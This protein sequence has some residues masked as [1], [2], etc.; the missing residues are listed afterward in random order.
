MQIPTKVTSSKQKSN[1]WV[2]FSS[3][4]IHP[5]PEKIETITHWPT[6][7]NVHEMRSFLGLFGFYKKFVKKYSCIA[8]PLTIITRKH[9]NSHWG[10]SQQYVFDT[11]KHSLSHAPILQLP[12]FLE[13]FL[14]VVANA[15][16]SQ[17]GKFLCKMI[18]QLHLKVEK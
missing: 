16:G 14:V 13:P 4:G 11:L 15:S 2:I 8:L 10:K 18:F 7:K 5:N 12:E 9:T 17:I 6:P 1:A 3:N